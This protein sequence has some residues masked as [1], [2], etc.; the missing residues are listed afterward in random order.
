M[1]TKTLTTVEEFEQLPRE[2]ARRFEL[3][4]EELVEVSR[5][6]FDH[7]VARD[8]FAET[9]RRFARER[10]LGVV[11]AEQEFRLSA[12]TVRRPDVAFV[13]ATKAAA[14][15]GQKRIQHLV[16]DLVVEVA[17]DSDSFTGLMRKVR[18]YLDN[19]V[20]M[21]LV[22]NLPLAETTVFHADGRIV[23]LRAADTLSAED[24][25]PGFSCG[26]AQFFDPNY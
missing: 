1:A 13:S 26:V 24:V 11:V 7:N 25:L 20:R 4:E 19:G 18:Q 9:L 2:E 12:R 22:V 21:V 8:R 6:I 16:P 15:Q 3:D 10:R 17:S 5:A 23:L 14:I